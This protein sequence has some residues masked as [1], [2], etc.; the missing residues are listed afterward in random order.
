MFG[1]KWFTRT[2]I[3]IVALSI[4]GIFIVIVQW[5]QAPTVMETSEL[6]SVTVSTPI[7]VTAEPT[8]LLIEQ[9]KRSRPLPLGSVLEMPDLSLQIVEARDTTDYEMARLHGLL[10]PLVTLEI[11]LRVQ[12]TGHIDAPVIV[13]ERQNFAI[14]SAYG[15]VMQLASDPEDCVSAGGFYHMAIYGGFD[16]LIK[17][18]F[19]LPHEEGFLLTYT[20][21]LTTVDTQWLML[22]HY[23][24]P[25]MFQ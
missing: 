25:F 16:R 6:A 23:E 19:R 11:M 20:S 4:A 3:G 2:I 13:V 5:D 7:I 15:L 18:C 1:S 8:I 24:E 12:H 9:T 17:L 14:V 21:P 22:P 10:N